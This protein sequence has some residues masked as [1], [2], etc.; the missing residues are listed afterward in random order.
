ML[1]HKLESELAGILAWCVQGTLDWQRYG[2]AA[3]P[4]V[5]LETEEYR[6]EQDVLAGFIADRCVEGPKL[7]VKSDPLYIAYKDW[8]QLNGAQ[9]AQ[10]AF[11]I[12]LKERGYV[13]ARKKSG[14]VW[15]GIGLRSD[16][17]P[18]PSVPSD[19][20]PTPPESSVDKPNAE[21]IQ[22]KGVG[23]VPKTG[24][25]ARAPYANYGVNPK[26]PTPPYTTLHPY[27]PTP[28]KSVAE[29]LGEIE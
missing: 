22:R 2:L 7:T 23:C 4:E 3:P 14:V 27:T 8:C 19:V 9:Q 16:D 25:T 15:S 10:K 17:D 24:L 28:S 6:E 26:N 18:T 5:E 29:R 21:D 1:L 12:R 13:K 20:D 11:S